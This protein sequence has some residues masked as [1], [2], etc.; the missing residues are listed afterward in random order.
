MRDCFNR[1]T[2]E[3]RDEDCK[4]RETE[5]FKHSMDVQTERLPVFATKKRC[6]VR[7]KTKEQKNSLKE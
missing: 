4:R 3:F 2:R 5:R 1:L 6:K 7:Q